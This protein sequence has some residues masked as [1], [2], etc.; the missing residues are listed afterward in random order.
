[1]LIEVKVKVTRTIDAKKRKLF[2][3]YIL[4]KEF[5]AEAEY[6]V[7]SLLNNEVTE[8]TAESFEIQSLRVSTIK[9]IVHQYE[10]T[11][12]FIATLKD[13]Y[14]DEVGNEKTMKYKVLLW[15]NDLTSATANIRQLQREGYDM[16]VEGLKEVN[17]T[18][19]H[20]NP[21]PAA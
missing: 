2:E 14:L 20:P 15:A 10:G 4:E 8:G 12:S 19:L 16:S 11:T 13:T 3:T 9:E 21:Q 5:F 17:Y 18:Y 7:T 1:M 6:V